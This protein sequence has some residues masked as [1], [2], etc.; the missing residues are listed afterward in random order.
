MLNNPPTSTQTARWRKP[1]RTVSAANPSNVSFQAFPVW[2][3]PA[4]LLAA[5]PNAADTGPENGRVIHGF[6]KRPGHDG[7]VW[8]Q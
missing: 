2:M 4:V 8:T 5:W 3:P 6:P 1:A 7:R